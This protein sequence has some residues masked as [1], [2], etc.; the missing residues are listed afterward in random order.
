MSS[1]D[2]LLGRTIKNYRIDA[3]LGQGGMGTV[4]RATDTQLLRPVA[5]KVMHP[6]FAIQP[7]FQQR[8]LQEARASANLDHPNI[9]RIYEFA[10][11]GRTLYLVTELVQ[12]GSLRD[13]LKKLYDERKFIDV[14][15]ALALTRQVAYALD[16]AHKQG[17][18]HRD[19]KPDNVLLKTGSSSD[20]GMGFRA[21]LTDFGLAKLAEG[22]IQSLAGNPTGTLPYMSPEQAMAEQLDGRTDV[23]ALGIM[24]YELTTGRL[25]FMPRSIPEAIKM[26]T[27]VEPERPTAARKSLS[28]ELENV[29][30]KA[31]AKKPA[32]RYQSAAEF[33]RAIA[34]VEKVGGQVKRA[35]GAGGAAGAAAVKEAAP[36]KVESLSTYLA[37][38]APVANPNFGAL[39]DNQSTLDQIIVQVEGEAPR[40]IPITK[41]IMEVGR[42]PALDVALQSPKV[43][44]MHAK[45]ERRPDGKYA[46]TDLGSSNGTY[47]A[48]VKLLSNVQEVWMPEKMVRIGGFFLTLQMAAATYRTGVAVQGTPSIVPPGVVPGAVSGGNIGQGINTMQGANAGFAGMSDR[49]DLKLQPAMMMIEAGQRNDI[50]VQIRN[51]SE[52][53]EHYQFHVDGIPKEWY[54]LP[55]TTL[56]L[57]TTRDGDA[58]SRGSV[59]IAFHPPRNCKSTGGQHMVTIRVTSQD[60]GKEVGRIQFP[61]TINPF[62]NYKAD[63]QPKK[64]R[65]RGNLRIVIK[66]EGNAPESYTLAPS[67]REESLHFDPPIQSINAAPCLDEVAVFY[68]RAIRRPFFALSSKHYPL[69]VDVTASGSPIA[70]PLNGELVLSPRIPWW[71]L[72]LLLLLCLLCF[73]LIFLLQCPLFQRNCPVVTDNRFATVTAGHA[74]LNGWLTGTA[75]AFNGRQTATISARQGTATA[76]TATA[77]VAGTQGAA[78]Q[79]GLAQTAN[80]IATNTAQAKAAATERQSVILTAQG[81]R[82]TP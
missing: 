28:P 23:Y 39:P 30:L 36:E 72:F 53:V 21:I 45:I 74:T 38:M 17:L 44:R 49:I 26:H 34:E 69:T 27:S 9:I 20:D 25:P 59:M 48:D 55:M 19:V 70:Q 67:D 50:Q 52:L 2:P 60:R 14:A 75:T 42:D 62:Y 35:A 12:G 1:S 54:T 81:P 61:L 64:I 24:L 8:F 47:L 18:I 57:M 33:A 22:G 77:V 73:L 46:I 51:L 41:N 16:F 82:P 29:I 31:I 66:N 13:Y 58:V 40:T 80:A 37:S 76:Q 56:Q 63:L 68:V 3:V 32:E 4:Y 7:E 43:S 6:N 15:E 79:T 65:N 5:L 11:D 10:L 78:V 71:L